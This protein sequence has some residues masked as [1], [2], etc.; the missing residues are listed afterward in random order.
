[1]LSDPTRQVVEAVIAAGASI[2][3][4]DV[5]KLVPEFAPN[6]GGT[7]DLSTYAFK[8]TAYITDSNPAQDDLELPTFGVVDASAYPTMAADG[9]GRTLAGNAGDSI[10]VVISGNCLANVYHV[11]VPLT[12]SCWLYVG[13][14][15]VGTGPAGKFVTAE[16]QSTATDQISTF[17][18]SFTDAGHYNT[19]YQTIRAKALVTNTVG[20]ADAYVVAPVMVFNN[21]IGVTG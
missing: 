21:P 6:S 15:H 9:S 3:Y 8:W 1:M 16:A 18:D 19:F 17:E 7:D 20:A 11:T 5:V 10:S 14:S 12:K 13:D 4:G 2:H